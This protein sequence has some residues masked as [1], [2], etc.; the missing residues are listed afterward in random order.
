MWEICAAPIFRP[1]MKKKQCFLKFA[2]AMNIFTA[3]AGG[4]LSQMGKALFATGNKY[5][6]PMQES[7]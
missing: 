7:L 2:C 3:I 5:I 1:A 6:L 4:Y